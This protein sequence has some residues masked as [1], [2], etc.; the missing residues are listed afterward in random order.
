MKGLLSL[1]LSVFVLS[2]SVEKGSPDVQDFFKDFAKSKPAT[3][4]IYLSKKTRE[5]ISDKNSPLNKSLISFFN[6]FKKA[7]WKIINT[8]IRKNTARVDIE[9]RFHPVE[10][11]RG[12][13]SNFF[14]VQENSGWKLDFFHSLD[15]GSPY[16]SNEKVSDYIKNKKKNY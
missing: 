13:R 15:G 7:D 12:F 4:E 8:E 2:C 1:V 10:N 11:R 5:F 9:Y 14:L 6:D 3:F 16:R